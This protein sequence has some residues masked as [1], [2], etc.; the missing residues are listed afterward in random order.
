MF[1]VGSYWIWTSGNISGTVSFALNP[2]RSYLMTGALVGKD[3]GNYGQVY[4]SMLC[5]VSGDQVLC[6]IRDD[7]SDSTFDDITRLGITEFISSA[8]S[9]TVKLRGTGGL[10]RAEGILY[11]IT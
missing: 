3:G 9:V 8:D 1:V 7:P 4:I 5:T 6:G 2:A 10:H 11:D